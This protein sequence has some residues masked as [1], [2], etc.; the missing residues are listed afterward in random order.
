MMLSLRMRDENLKSR[1]FGAAVSRN[2]AMSIDSI[3]FRL[4]AHIGMSG[5]RIRQRFGDG[6]AQTVVVHAD[7]LP[8]G[9]GGALSGALLGTLAYFVFLLAA[10]GGA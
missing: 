2:L 7:S 10:P 8:S 6:L 3:L 9:S 5:S 1:S 4:V